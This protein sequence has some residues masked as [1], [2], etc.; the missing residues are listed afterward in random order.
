[1][2][3]KDTY[4]IAE[5]LSKHFTGSLTEVEQEALDN[6][7]NASE[8]NKALYNQF[9][10]KGFFEEKYLAEAATDTE[11]VLLEFME[12]KDYPISRKHFFIRNVKYIAAAAL[13]LICG[14]VFYQSQKSGIATQDFNAV[15]EN[16]APG[17]KNAILTLANGKKVYLNHSVS[18]N[19]GDQDITIIKATDSSI[20]YQSSD[21]L[22]S[23]TY[24]ELETPDKSEYMITLADGTVVWLNAGSKIRYPV[25]F[26]KNERR[27]ELSGE[28]YFEVTKD[29]TKPFIIDIGANSVQVLGTSFNVKAYKNDHDIHTTLVE[30]SVRMMTPAQS[31]DLKPNEQGIINLRTQHITKIPVDVSLYTSWK[32]GRFV[33][34]DQPLSEIMSAIS[35]WY[36]IDVVFENQGARNVTFTGTL[37][38]YDSLNKVINMLEMTEQVKFKKEGSTIYIRK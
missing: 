30:G 28:A 19:I 12:R 14:L 6:W 32:N 18:G 23:L 2:E 4:Q 20:R 29:K 5:L 17:T 21:Q 38:R 26:V 1:M 37:K 16:I 31:M 7:L 24:N 36:G 35:R 15:K 9:S 8:K 10:S 13:F 22:Q 25:K 27:I 3:L 34:E 33:F 11:A